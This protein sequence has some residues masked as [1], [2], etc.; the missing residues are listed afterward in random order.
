MPTSSGT[1]VGTSQAP[2]PTL[3]RSPRIASYSQSSW[4]LDRIACKKSHAI[5]SKVQKVQ[6]SE[7]I[8]AYPAGKNKT[9]SP[10]FITWRFIKHSNAL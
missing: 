3:P 2:L 4:T 5:L 6:T 8:P 7:K 10:P 9:I 1:T